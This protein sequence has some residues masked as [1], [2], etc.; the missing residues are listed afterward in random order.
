MIGGSG[1]L[2]SGSYG[3][4]ISI[5][6]GSTFS[7]ASSASQTLSGV[8]SGDGDVEKI[9]NTSTLMLSGDNTYTGGTNVSAGYLKS[10]SS[11]GAS[12]P[13]SGPFGTA[14]VTVAAGAVLDVNGQTVGNAINLSGTGISSNGAIINSS[15]TAATISADITLAAHSSVGGSNAV[16]LSGAISGGYNFTKVGSSTYT[17]S[18]TNTYTGDTTITTGTL[19]LIGR[20]DTATD[21]IIGSNGTLDL[22]ATQTF[23]TLD[24]DGAIS[25]TAGTSSLVISGAASMQGTAATTGTQTYSGAVTLTDTTTITTSSAKVTFAAAATINSQE[26]E[27]NNLT[28]N[29]SE[30]E[31]NGAMGGIGVIDINANLD[32]DAAITNATSIDVSG[33]SNLGANVTTSGTQT[34]TGAVTLSAATVTLTTTNSD[35][36]FGGTIDSDAGQTRNLTINTGGTTGT[37]QFGGLVG[38]TVGLGAISITGNLDLDANIVDAASLAVSG[39]SNLGANVTTSGTQTYTGDITLSADVGLNTLGGNVQIDGDV[40][41]ALVSGGSESGIIQF[42]GSGSYKYSTDSG[43]T[44]STGTASGSSTTLGTG[45]LTYSSGSYSWTTPDNVTSTKLLVVAG[46]G[47]GGGS[48]AGAG[49]GAGG[50]VYNTAYSVTENTAYSVTIGSGGTGGTYGVVGSN[51]TS[52]FF[53]AVEAYGG[54]GGGSYSGGS[55]PPPAC[56]TNGCG[57]SGGTGWNVSNAYIRT[58]SQ[59]NAG[60]GYQAGVNNCTGNNCSGNSGGAGG[61][62]GGAGQL[63]ASA[64]LLSTN[65]N[66][67]SGYYSTS[68]TGGVGLANSIT[69]TSTYYAGGGGSGSDGL[70]GNGGLGGGGNGGSGASAPSGYQYTDGLDGSANTGGGGGG[71][72]GNSQTPTGGDGGSGIVVVNYSYNA[73]TYAEYDLSINTGA[74]D[75]DINSNLANLGELNLTSTSAGS[76]IS[77]IISTDTIVN[78]AGSGTLTLSGNNTFTGDT[79]ITTGTLTVTGTLADTTDVSVAS[80]AV[81]D[82]DQ[83]DT[84]QSLS[85]AGTINIA[86]TKTL[87]FGDATNDKTISGAIEGAGSI[88]KTGSGTLTLSATNTYTGD[89]TISAGT[90]KLTGNLNSATDLV[91]DTGAT[92]DLQAA[93]TAA[94]LT[95]NGTISNTANTSSLTISGTSNLG[96]DVTTTGTQTYTRRG[97]LKC[98]NGD[99]NHH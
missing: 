70:G 86:S 59:G 48:F 75:I 55:T 58:A 89:T 31:F 18:G 74:G 27:T 12:P 20:L 42:L 43:S 1:Q 22:Q 95:L 41:T 99:F 28:I 37:I 5:A 93:L 46:G 25:N 63:N 53:G 73:A 71:G 84:I 51:G 39:A 57:S 91:I 15:T 32:L 96:G 83:T 24:L 50:Y 87:T 17:L 44:Y 47:G 79:T 61:G 92:L 11:S 7:F 56:P 23:A 36:T 81:Y 13:T 29:A 38:D 64:V 30:V 60:T 16:T 67:P 19:K 77:G 26:G 33:T 52:S 62:A 14:T 6:S 3:G 49:G 4:A 8:I 72:G 10:G 88:E 69:G 90:L 94:T 85:G 78:K 21:L 65:A 2:G 66:V 9:T 34:Y 98:S 76:E 35:V 40:N 45:S 82:V 97:D 80:G 54:G 68:P